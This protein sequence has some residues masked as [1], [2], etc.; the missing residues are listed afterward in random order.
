[1]CGTPA[2]L[3]LPL[4]VSSPTFLSQQAAGRGEGGARLEE[5]SNTCTLEKGFLVHL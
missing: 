1:M 2:S 5:R 3:S 4:P